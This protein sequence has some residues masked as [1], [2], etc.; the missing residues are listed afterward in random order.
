[1]KKTSQVLMV[2]LLTL[3][4][5][6]SCCNPVEAQQKPTKNKPA[7]RDKVDKASK[8]DWSLWPSQSAVQTMI[9][10]YG[11]PVEISPEAA[12]WYDQGP[13]KRIRVMSKGSGDARQNYTEYTIAYPNITNDRLQ[14]LMAFDSNIV[15]NK[16][17]GEVSVRYDLESQNVRSLELAREILDGKTTAQEARM[18]FAQNTQNATTKDTMGTTYK[19]GTQ[20]PPIKEN[21]PY[22]E[23]PATPADMRNSGQVKVNEGEILAFL[24]A[25]NQHEISAATAAEG[26]EIS[27]RV[28]EYAKMLHTH[29]SSNLEK[30]LAL[31]DS[32]NIVAQETEDIQQFRT[33]GNEELAKL[34]ALEG[35]GFESAYLD[36]MIKGH[37]EVLEWID[38]KFTNAAKSEAL[39]AHL[40]ETRMQVAMHLEEAKK[41]KENR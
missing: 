20:A 3:G 12:V 13:Y 27:E 35:K 5:Y 2:F 4:V 15:V 33:K 38:R 37:T 26:K 30:T 24:A 14:E 16:K 6:F 23:K 7:K 29:H 1:M 34:A 41:L 39:K 28:A 31:S 10:Q 18:A 25:V 40:N 22:A 9:T 21:V 11:E 32:I 36:A 8:T 19:K 17:K